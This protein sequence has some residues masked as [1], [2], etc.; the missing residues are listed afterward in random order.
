MSLFVLLTLLLSL[1]LLI[2]LFFF[3]RSD[4]LFEEEVQALLDGDRFELK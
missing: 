3:V 1:V 4:R 2:E